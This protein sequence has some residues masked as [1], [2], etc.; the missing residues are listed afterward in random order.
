VAP[1]RR[2]SWRDAWRSP[3]TGGRRRGKLLETTGDGVARRTYRW[4]IIV[5]STPAAHLC[6]ARERYQ[7]RAAKGV[8]WR[9]SIWLATS[10]ALGSIFSGVAAT[11]SRNKPAALGGW[12]KTAKTATARQAAEAWLKKKKKHGGKIE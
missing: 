10:G 5:K 6:G 12:R 3:A 2:L 4:R 7:N 9:A 11:A 8:A 1:T